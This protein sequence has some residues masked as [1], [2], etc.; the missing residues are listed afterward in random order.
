MRQQKAERD[1]WEAAA[2]AGEEW[3]AADFEPI[4]QAL[5]EVPVSAIMAAIGLSRGACTAVRT[6]RESCHPRHWPALAALVG[7]E[8]RDAVTPIDSSP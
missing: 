1:A 3:D 2:Y 8:P 4:R 6:G 5:G 7:Q